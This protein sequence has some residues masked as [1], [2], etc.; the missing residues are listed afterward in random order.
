MQSADKLMLLPDGKLRHYIWHSNRTHDDNYHLTHDEHADE[1]ADAGD[2]T[3]VRHFDF[4]AGQYCMEKAVSSGGGGG[5][6]KPH[7]DAFYALI[8]SP[9]HV[10]RWTDTDF[11]LRKIINPICH[12]ISMAILLVIAIVYFVLPTLR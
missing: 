9:E 1:A 2:Q 10:V 7:A 11:L 5:A 6:E 3:A 12:G 4:P 8:C